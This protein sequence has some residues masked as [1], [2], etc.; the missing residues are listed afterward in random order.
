MVEEN[1]ELTP[2]P[3]SHPIGTGMGAAGGAA[4]G[5]VVGAA[6][7]GPVGAIAGAA[8]GGVAGA[9]AGHK[10]AEAINPTPVSGTEDSTV[11]GRRSQLGL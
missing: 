10:A 11:P 8:V 9:A 5:A 7:G 1:I 3:G 2:K 4:G 6:L